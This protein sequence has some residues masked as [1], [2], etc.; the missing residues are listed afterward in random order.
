MKICPT[1]KEE[2]GP[3]IRDAPLDPPLVGAC[4]FAIMYRVAN[5]RTGWTWCL[6]GC[7]GEHRRSKFSETESLTYVLDSIR[8]YFSI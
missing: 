8:V 6:R 5:F 2:G 7:V 3:D 4:V 1:I